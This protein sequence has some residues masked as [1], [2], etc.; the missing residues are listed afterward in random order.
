MNKGFIGILILIVVV[1]GGYFLYRGGYR[2]SQESDTLATSLGVPAPGF[3]SV[4]ETAVSPTSQ[5]SIS[6]INQK[7]GTSVL[8]QRAVLSTPGYIVVHEEQDGKPGPVIGNSGLFEGVRQNLSVTLLRSSIEGEVLFAMLHSDDGDGIYEFPGGDN[9]T[10]DE[11]G[12]VILDKFTII[13]EEAESDQEPTATVSQ[14]KEISM[15]SSNFLFS[16]NSM[17]LEKDQP[18]KIVFQNSGTHTFTINELDVNASLS[19][20]SAD[21]EFIPTRSGTFE[22]YCAIPG[23]RERGMFGLITVE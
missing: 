20:S 9:P 21:A 15:V 17:T 8:I 10:K 14:V 2:S 5:D 4:P 12:S 13:E 23:H 7:T 11:E 3:D 6:A 22:Y 19:G 18:V 1:V 16:P